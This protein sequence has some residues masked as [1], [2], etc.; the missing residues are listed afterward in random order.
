MMR[1]SNKSIFLTFVFI[2]LLSNLVLGAELIV[3]VD[4][5]DRN[6][7]AEMIE[8]KIFVS[9]ESL[10]S[11][12]LDSQV[13]GNEITIENEDVEFIF[14]LDSNQVKVNGLSFTLASK[15]YSKGNLVYLPLR[16][17]LETLN[18]K[19]DWSS[20]TNKVIANKQAETQFPLVIEDGESRYVVEGEAATI[21]SMA[22]GVTEKLF[23]LGVGDR[24]KG[25]TQYC[26]YPAEANDIEN[27]GSLYEPN[28]ELI[29][30]ISPDIVIAESFFKQGILD[31]LEE[32]GINTVATSTASNMED[33]YDYMLNLGVIVGKEYEARGLVASLKDKVSRVK[34]IL[35][36]ITDSEKPSVYYVVGTGQS[37]EY[38][39]GRNTFIS[40]LLSIT[41]AKNVADDVEGWNYSLEKLIDHDP[42]YIIGA[43]FNIETMLNGDNYQVLSAIQNNKYLLV[44]EDI[45]S[46]AAPRAVDEGLKTLIKLFHKDKVKELN[47]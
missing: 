38:T 35:R 34:Y 39:A 23:A 11:F 36:D 28:L 2:L 24:I 31:K 22:P 6:M 10:E 9:T 25:R 37:G 13:S 15:T 45:F 5:V 41:G 29:L 19:I 26:D 30:D 47:F 42:D 4:G 7:A 16:F 18:Y 14:V 40:K 44:N 8:S 33:V 20:N 21:V 3:N 17:I 1:N 27:I 46:R 12:G 43:Q 32:A